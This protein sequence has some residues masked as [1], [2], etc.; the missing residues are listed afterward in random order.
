MQDEEVGVGGEEEE[1]DGTE[2]VEWCFGRSKKVKSPPVR[3][4]E[5][6]SI[7]V[8]IIALV[9]YDAYIRL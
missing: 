4:K 1:E 3:V 7:L 8:I 9:Q 5:S 2:Y 6:L